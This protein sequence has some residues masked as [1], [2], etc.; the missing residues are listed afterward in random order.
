MAESLSFDR[1]ADRYDETRGGQRRGEE[2]AAALAPHLRPGRSLEIGVGTGLVADALARRHGV[3][4]AGVDLSPAMLS[5]AYARLGPRV[6]VGDARRLPVRDASVDNAF[7]V[8]ALHV[9]VD[10]AT[11]FTEA[12]R[13]V[14]PGG[15]V[16][17]LSASRDRGRHDAFAPLLA[18]LPNRDRVDT[19]DAVVAAAH[20]AGLR[21][22]ESREVTVGAA[23]TSPNEIAETI[24]TRAWSYLWNVDGAVWASTVAPIVQGLRDLPD[25]DEPRERRIT[26][27]LSVFEKAEKP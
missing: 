24:E 5:H 15:R 8:G 9:I 11:A 6:T 27:Q 3:T 1:V 16:L 22:R 7:F 23:A 26:F 17:A 10:L 4:T 12:A 19:P 13:V 25:P 21:T 20:E 14:R 18:G 2:F